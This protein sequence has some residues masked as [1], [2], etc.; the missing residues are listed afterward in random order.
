MTK[1]DEDLN[2]AIS[3]AAAILGRRGGKANKG[4]TSPARKAASSANGKKG[5]RPSFASLGLKAKA[6]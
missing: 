5:G 4:K 1:P 3:E 2:R 6:E